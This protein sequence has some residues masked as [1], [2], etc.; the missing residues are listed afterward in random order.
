[1]GFG[2][3]ANAPRSAASNRLAASCSLYCSLFFGISV[4]DLWFWA[5]YFLR[6]NLT[7]GI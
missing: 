6:R 2:G 5:E 7:K 3:V 1:M 4:S